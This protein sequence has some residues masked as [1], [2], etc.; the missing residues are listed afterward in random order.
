VRSHKPGVT[1]FLL[2]V[3]ELVH[4]FVCKGKNC[5]E[6]AENIRHH[7][8]KFSH[9]GFVDLCVHVIVCVCDLSSHF[10]LFVILHVSDFLIYFS[11]LTFYVPDR[12]VFVLV[13]LHNTL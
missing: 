2:S 11:C 1:Q 3:C 4:I 7:H 6:S 8:T 13:L 9:T 5:N 10:E 12:I